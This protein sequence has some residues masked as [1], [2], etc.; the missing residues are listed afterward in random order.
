MIT[1]GPSRNVEE[2][3]ARLRTVADEHEVELVD[4][5]DGTI[6]IAVCLGG[7]G[8]ILRALTRFLGTGVPVIGANFGRV[9]YLTA[10][11]GEELES[12]IA[13]VFRGEYAV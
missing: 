1:A 7:D 4:G 10:I 8:T 9:G 11:R 3:V 2:P 6:D 5:E 12:G 13:R